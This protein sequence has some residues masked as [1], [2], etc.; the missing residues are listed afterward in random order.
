MYSDLPCNDF[1]VKDFNFDGLEDFAIVWDNGGNGGELYEYYF[2]HKSGMFSPTD[3]FPL[4][5][6]MLAEDINIANKTITTQS[7]VGCCHYN[8]N[9]YN[10]K[11]N[12][13]WEVLSEQK[14]LK[15]ELKK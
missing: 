2:Q 4:Q 1:I 3:S 8:L 6:G 5:H 13:N 9:T 12:G 15:K 11:S 14:E 7:V 10:L